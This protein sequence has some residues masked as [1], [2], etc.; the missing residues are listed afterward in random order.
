MQTICILVIKL[1]KVKRLFVTSFGCEIYRLVK[2]VFDKYYLV[3]K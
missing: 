1:T 2:F 3:T